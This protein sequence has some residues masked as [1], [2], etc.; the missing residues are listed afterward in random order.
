MDGAA[1]ADGSGSDGRADAAASEGGGGSGG[2]DDRIVADL[3]AHTTASDGEM[4]LADVPAAARRAGVDWVAITDHDRV[5]PGL[6]DP[7]ERRDGVWLVRG[8]ELRVETG[9][10]RVDL[11]GYGVDPT[12]AL[13]R[14]LDRLQRDRVDRG[15][16]MV[17]NVES[18]LGVDLDVEVAEGIGRPHVARA[19]AAAD[20][21]YDYRDAFAELIGDD[22]PCYVA[23]DVTDVDAGLSLL[24]DACALVALAHPLRYDDPVAALRVAAEPEVAAV[25]RH[26]PYDRPTDPT[27]V[28]A[29]VREHGLLATGG[30]DAHDDRLGRAGLDAAG[31]APVRERLPVPDSGDADGSGG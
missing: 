28:D 19:I 6:D 7:V 10:E 11:L 3:H 12:P 15:R 25:E 16:R 27:P 31:F 8:I 23:R 2:S 22:G 26:Y 30:S 5:H 18:R 4:A 13:T 9:S 21:D 1:D 24:A 29:A 17:A 14:E 20:A